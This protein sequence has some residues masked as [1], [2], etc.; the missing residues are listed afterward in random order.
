VCCGLLGLC[1]DSL[2]QVIEPYCKH[3]YK[4]TKKVN[5]AVLE[6]IFKLAKSNR[7][8]PVQLFA[9]ALHSRRCGAAH[10]DLLEQAQP[11]YKNNAK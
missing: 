3:W 10:I 9:R 4:A 1:V 7:D 5:K 8:F 2:L 11:G 6:R